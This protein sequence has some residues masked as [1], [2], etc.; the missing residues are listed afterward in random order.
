MWA[1]LVVRIS[2]EELRKDCEATRLRS[3]L[4]RSSLVALGVGAIIGTGIFVITGL[5]AAQHAGPAVVLSFLIAGVVSGLAG[6]CY[7]ELSA[8][9]AVSG[10]A[11]AY[12]YAIF[13]EF[14][15]WFI[16][17][18]LVLEYLFSA[19]TIAVGWSSYLERLISRGKWGPLP[20]E[21]VHSPFPDDGTLTHAAAAINVPA[22]AIALLMTA[23]C[24]RGIRESAMFN[25]AVV[26]VKVSVILAVVLL[27]AAFVDVR[28][29]S[30]F[31]PP[32]RG[33]FGS[34]GW[35]GVLQAAGIV[36]FAY[37][38]FDAVATTAQEAKNPS[39]DIPF[40][41]LGS[42]SICALLYI[43][44]AGVITGLVPYAKLADAAPVEIA[45]R[46]HPELRWLDGV[47]IFGALTGLTSAMLVMI[48]AQ[49]R[50]FMSMGNHGLLPPIF[51][52]I[53]PRY[54][55]PSGAT[56]FT[57]VSIAVLAGL[58]PIGLLAELVSIGTLTAFLF[59]C[60][61]VLVLRHSK[62]EYH[63]P[64]RVPAIWIVALLGAGCCLALIFSLPRSSLV[65]LIVWTGVGFLIYFL[66]GYRHSR[67]GKSSRESST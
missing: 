29:W 22:I 13:G 23:I 15:A 41:I 38:G 9:V 26:V 45:V 52:S 54:Q 58:L 21:F 7:A 46:S 61:G 27:G 35:S 66:Y 5:A 10:S 49:S 20:M 55:T 47:V 4:G 67:V 11:Y 60:I 39:R 48:L 32:N 3:S 37:I 19:A 51:G 1:R 6:L 57:G 36:F 28:N 63:R 40:G 30:P 50:I 31:I 62:P 33:S 2:L 24:Y 18:N 25:L 12:T 65:R 8:T 64:F 17:W 34:F 53:H 43:A 59:V 44:V 14:A 16:G 42:L 56:V